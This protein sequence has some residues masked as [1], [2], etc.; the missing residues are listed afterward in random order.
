MTCGL[1]S[2]VRLLVNP[3]RFMSCLQFMIHAVHARAEK[4]LRLDCWWKHG[5]SGLVRRH[6]MFFPNDQLCGLAIAGLEVLVSDCLLRNRALPRRLRALSLSNIHVDYSSN[7]ECGLGA[8]LRG[9][10][11]LEHLSIDPGPLHTRQLRVAFAAL[12]RCS[13]LTYLA[14]RRSPVNSSATLG[15]FG[16][17]AIGASLPPSLRVVAP[18]HTA[19]PHR[20]RFWLQML[21]A[22][23]QCHSIS[24]K[25]WRI[26]PALLQEGLGRAAGLQYLWCEDSDLRSLAAARARNGL[27][28]LITDP[29]QLWEAR[30]RYTAIL[31]TPQIDYGPCT[32]L[33]T[34]QLDT[35]PCRSSGAF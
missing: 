20:I 17:G 26:K 27:P 24:L 11:A 31:R 7:V 25:G 33:P 28:P 29:E 18:E 30:S 32:L 34:P 23:P 5:D 14:L 6:A 4:C 16:F 21:A 35:T 12:N 13:A 15:A 19:S 2:A 22:L 9:L 8:T 1:Q 3:F 10:T